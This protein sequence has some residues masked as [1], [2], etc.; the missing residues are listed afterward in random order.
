M[1]FGEGWL[2][3][4]TSAVWCGCNVMSVCHDWSLTSHSVNSLHG[5][6]QAILVPEVAVGVDGGITTYQS[7]RPQRSSV[8]PPGRRNGR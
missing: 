8:I 1:L 5:V 4:S 6:T 2:S 7:H 3:G